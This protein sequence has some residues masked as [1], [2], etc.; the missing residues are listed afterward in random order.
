M[1]PL[2]HRNQEG[3]L[4]GTEPE[5]IYIY[6]SP[7]AGPLTKEWDTD[8]A[9]CECGS[10]FRAVYHVPTY[11]RVGRLRCP[12]CFRCQA[13]IKALDSANDSGRVH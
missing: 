2:S 9:I 5:L 13:R 12:G 4:S 3:P 11:L 7:G 10:E 8:V 1:A 6:E